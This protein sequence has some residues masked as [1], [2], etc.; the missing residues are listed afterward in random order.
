MFILSQLLW[1]LACIHLFWIYFFITG[2]LVRPKEKPATEPDN[3]NPTNP[4]SMADLVITT[5][6]GIAIT[7][8]VILLFGFISLLSA[9]AFLLWLIIEG[10]LFKVLREE[11]VFGA[12]FWLGRFKLAK[13]A[14]SLPA[15]IIYC[16]FLII[17]VPAILPPTAFD[18]TLY[19]L[20]YA[21]DWA[22]AGQ[23]YADELLRF[24][25]YA[26]NFHLLYTLM[27]VLKIGPLVHFLN[28]LCGLLTGL[29]VYSAIAEEIVKGPD[30]RPTW[31]ARRVSITALIIALGLGL[32]PVFLRWVDT[33]FMDISITLFLFV[34][35]LC[36]YIG[37]Q[38]GTRN[39][40]LEFLL[41][42]AFCVGIKI[43]FFLFLPL[44]IVSLI[45]LLMKRRRPLSRVIVMTILLLILSAPWYV[46]N[47]IRTGD[48]ISPTLNI[49]FKHRD[50]IWSPADSAA[51]LADLTTPKDPVTLIRLPLD[52]FWHTTANN[53]RDYGTSPVVVL[54]YVPFV[55][56][57]L[58]LFGRVRKW[59][60]APFVYL[61]VVLLYLL[62][63]W[64]GISSFARYFLHL[65]PVYLVYIGVLLNTLLRFSGIDRKSGRLRHAANL[66]V[67]VSLALVMFVPSPTARIYYEEL[68]Q[69]N[70]LQLAIRFRSYRQYLRQNLPGY[71]S[72][73]YIIANLQYHR[74]EGERVMLV[75]FENLT[76]Y[77][78]KNRIVSFGDWVGIGRHSDLIDSINS[79]DLSSYLAKFNVGA[80][81][82]NAS[83]K[84]MDEAT[85]LLFTKQLEENQFV[86]QP[87]QENGTVIY[88]KAK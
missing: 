40:E 32:S 69:S 79:C 6:T 47:F 86:L 10:F 56:G 8:F 57:V 42:A 4:F 50:P 87:T 55:M 61:N 58:L 16:V 37:L 65:F 18:A 82:I 25:Y 20:A 15:L 83:S 1:C 19:H 14:W 36:I 9:G 12:V 80:V 21:V 52:L 74:N 63:Y 54:L 2:T 11:N 22:N 49:L 41:T 34:P 51:V 48:P 45:L 78:R 84:R 71:P 64:M 85:Y 73:Q 53:L 59:F 30:D 13:R 24:P 44:F 88:I 76:Y 31:P 62:A 29:A 5:A 43:A 35:I 75:G 28:W 26:N 3:T 7:G 46:R 38:T 33:G 60:G 72:T 70:Y 27:F 77:F 67:T 23:I 17:S 39:Y 81:L 66:L 68:V